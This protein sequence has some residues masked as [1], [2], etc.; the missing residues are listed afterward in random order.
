MF[1]GTLNKAR[2]SLYVDV[3]KCLEDFALTY[4]IHE[5]RKKHLEI[6]GC[7]EALTNTA[8]GNGARI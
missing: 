5:L 6:A 8:R 2:L 4:S 1:R 3:V 7:L